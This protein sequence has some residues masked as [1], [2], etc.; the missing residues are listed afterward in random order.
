MYN[1]GH[2]TRRGAFENLALAGRPLLRCITYDD[3]GVKPT[4]QLRGAVG[5]GPA[6]CALAQASH[7]PALAH[8]SVQGLQLHLK[9]N[10]FSL[11]FSETLWEVRVAA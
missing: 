2:A 5:K 8:L 4:E 9:F 3:S 10:G 1:A 11:M 6:S 7:W